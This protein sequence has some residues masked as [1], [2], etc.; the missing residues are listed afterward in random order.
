MNRFQRIILLAGLLAVTGFSLFPPYQ[1]EATTYQIDGRKVGPITQDVGHHWIRS[2]QD[3]SVRKGYLSNAPTM[4][5][6]SA[7]IDWQ[8]LSIY[9]G[10]MAAFCLFLAFVIFKNSPHQSKPSTLEE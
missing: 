3:G 1:W 10:L 6:R 4:E 5:S 7:R 8:R 9:T 2:P